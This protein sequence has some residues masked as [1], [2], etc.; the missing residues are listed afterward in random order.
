MTGD[1]PYPAG[2]ELTTAHLARWCRNA[3]SVTADHAVHLDRINVMF[4]PDLD[5]GRN[6]TELWSSLIEVNNRLLVHSPR[7]VP[8]Q[9]LLEAWGEDSDWDVVGRSTRIL[10]RLFR[11]M[12]SAAHDGPGLDPAAFADVLCGAAAIPDWDRTL[13]G[14]GTQPGGAQPGTM[15]DVVVAAAEAADRF[16][17]S[18]FDTQLA[19]VATAARRATDATPAYHSV[20]R[21]TGVVDAGALGLSLALRQLP[22]AVKSTR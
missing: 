3:Q 4:D 5:T 8:P 19:A 2:N 15:I 11:A 17:R 20:L 12:A 10:R 16:R 1:R 6:L 18:G 14:T 7:R 9:V 21:R 22:D 13:S